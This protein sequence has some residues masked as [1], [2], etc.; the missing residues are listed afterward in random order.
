MIIT[1]D[2]MQSAALGVM[3]L[4]LGNLVENKFRVLRK[5]CIPTPVVGGLIFALVAWILKE[6]NILEFNIDTT[7]QTLAMTAFF[8]SVGF[9]ASFKSLKKG[10]LKVLVFFFCAVILVVLQN[11][12][13]ISLADLLGLH[14]L[15]GL[16]TGSIPMTGGHAT[17]GSFGI[18]IENAGIPG[19]NTIAFAAA[20]FGLLAGSMIGGPT[21]NRLITKYGLVDK[22]EESKLS[23]D[24]QFMEAALIE[25][26]EEPLV[27]RNFSI[28]AFELLIAMGIGSVLSAIIQDAGIT[29]PSYIGAMLLGAIMRN[30]SDLTKSYEVPMNE[31]NILGSIAL[32][33]FLA[34]AL[35]GLKLW[36]LAGLAIPLLIM[37]LAQVLLMFLYANLVTFRVLGKDYDAAVIAAGH[38]GFGL[39][40]TPN[41]IANMTSVV[42]KFGPSPTA[43]L[44]MPLVGAL[45]IDFLNAGII[46]F[47]MNMF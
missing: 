9:S 36:E 37:V 20:T 26:K 4:L 19:A 33:L 27:D 42:E 7:L 8:T 38:C 46:T 1:L 44:V 28:A 18:L 6:K 14:P 29:L 12:L 5:Y 13:G 32:A 17:A 10:G 40:A 3:V 47:F 39:G 15:I 24:D 25:N 16:A 11:I 43:F 34:M 31:I 30:I 35:M 2:M 23:T 22:K 21:A 45:F 41:G